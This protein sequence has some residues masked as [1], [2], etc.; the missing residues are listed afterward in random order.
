MIIA[1][2]A[3]VQVAAWADS[4]VLWMTKSGVSATVVPPYAG[5]VSPF[6]HQRLVAQAVSS[7]EDVERM[8]RWELAQKRADALLTSQ[9]GFVPDFR[10]VTVGGK[11]DGARGPR[12]LVGGSWVGVGQKLRVRLK[13]SPAAM[14]A[15][16]DI[17]SFDQTASDTMMQ[18]FKSKLA[19]SPYVSVVI[20]KVSSDSIDFQSVYGI[21]RV[22]FATTQDN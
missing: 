4:S 9:A 21:E 11:I 3:G 19:Q 15:I 7:T 18:R 2:L 17:T 16:Q 13:M 10:G 1:L 6:A 20:A 5:Q 12:V 14:A 8:Q 22:S